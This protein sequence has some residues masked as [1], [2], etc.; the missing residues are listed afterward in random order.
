MDIN[1]LQTF[2]E[3]AEKRSFSRSAE[4]LKLTQPAVSK[5]IA[6]LE[7]EVA[8]QLFDRVGRSVH[9]TEAGKVLLPAALRINSEVTRIHSELSTLGSEVG[10]TLAVG[11]AEHVGLDRLT[12]LLKTYKQKYAGV[13]LDLQFLKA[14]EALSK[15]DSGLLDMTL[16]AI[17]DV[18]AV[19]KTYP[20][21]IYV[22]FWRENLQ[23]VV[24]K[25][26]PLATSSAVAV[27]QLAAY[28]GILLQQHSAIR[29]SIDMAMSSHNL[30]AKAAMEASDFATTKSMAAI[31]LGWAC[32]PQSQVDESLTPIDVKDVDLSYSIALVRNPGRSLS[33]A[34]QAF[35]DSLPATVI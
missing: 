35:I 13:N 33:R 18:S 14:E 24:G 32:L 31:G 27:Q 11:V 25:S 28:P 10:G 7:A 17:S 1:N 29:K 6:A 22:E 30:E 9:L 4:S 16:F 8:S 26:H 21:L 19:R 5:R 20:Q 2:I 34:S 12:P 15:V 23:V 3:V